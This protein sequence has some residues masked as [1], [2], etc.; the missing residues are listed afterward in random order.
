MTKFKTPAQILLVCM[1]FLSLLTGCNNTPAEE[2]TPPAPPTNVP[3]TEIP[4]AEPAP[5]PVPGV[6]VL[7]TAGETDA[8]QTAAVQAQLE[9]LAQSGGQSL[10]VRAEINPADILPEWKQIILLAPP[11]N[12]PDLLNAAPQSQFVVVS[13]MELTPASNLSVIR[14]YPEEQAFIAGYAAVVIANDWRAAAML[15]SDEPLG[16]LKAAAFVK[17]GQY[18]C[19]LCNSYYSP[20]V[21]FPIYYQLP[22]ASAP[23]QW[24][25]GADE[26]ALSY[27]YVYYVAP[28]AASG[29]LLYTLATRSVILLGGQTPPA[30][31]VN[32]Y[33]ATI[34][35]NLTDALNTIWPAVSSGQGG[36][37]VKAGIE[38]ADI[39][40]DLFSPGK[41][42][43]V[44]KVLE[45]LQAGLI[46]P[47]DPLVE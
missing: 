16:A 38:L 12:L 42:T 45:D 44:Q 7:V 3:A 19:G 13:E 46:Y 37:T 21:R 43:L 28:E 15:P 29:D 35:Y 23:G 5:T 25:A 27:V 4:T 10:E 33:A 40:A 47:L 1:L 32:L 8:G 22:A 36:Q 6:T 18:F 11:A 34:R 20:V 31:V 30:E 41:Q 17:G 24:L 26:L 2:P 39:N 14:S 9:G